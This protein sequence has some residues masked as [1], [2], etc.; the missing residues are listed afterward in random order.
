MTS[1]G[2]VLV[3]HN[4]SDLLD[5][6]LDALMTQDFV[7]KKIIYI[8][9][10]AST[11]NTYSV[12]H[13]KDPT[14]IRYIYSKVNLGGAGGFHLGVKTAYQN[15]HTWIWLMDDDVI[16]AIDCLRYL[17]R[18]PD[19]KILMPTREN[20]QGK[21]AEYSALKYNLSN[22]FYVRPKRL[23][24]NDVY[25]TRTE[26][27]EFLLID[28]FTFEGVIIHRSV[29]EQVGFP[30]AQYFIRGDDTDYAQRIRLHGYSIYLVRDAK[31]IRQLEFEQHNTL[32]S[33][34]GYYM[35]RNIF[36]IHFLYGR[37]FLVRIK[38]YFL[39][40]GAFLTGQFKKNPNLSFRLIADARQ[41][42]RD[43]KKAL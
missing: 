2:I 30:F 21:L 33:W 18:Y 8:I 32:F 5:Q 31:V 26:L 3:T 38:P 4:R 41:I 27:P 6:V 11:D 22:P 7:G 24:V 36:V 17:L 16:P 23:A 1:V 19:K 13:S 39:I 9:D 12:V 15:N 14:S 34:K 29:V 10:N 35:Y 28:N 25:T 20:K 40:L 42:T 43:I 37:N